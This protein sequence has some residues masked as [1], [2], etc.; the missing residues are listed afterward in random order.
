MPI[1][2][3]HRF[4]LVADP[5]V[6]HALIDATRCKVAGKAVAIRME[7][8]LV[9]VAA[10]V[11]ALLRFI[12]GTPEAAISAVLRDLLQRLVIANDELT[13]RSALP[14]GDQ[15]LFQFGMN[16]DMPHGFGS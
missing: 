13:F 7:A 4:G 9:P 8:D 6:Y 16:V 15:F 10:L 5:F 11:K 14:P 1:A 12:H 2:L 3:P